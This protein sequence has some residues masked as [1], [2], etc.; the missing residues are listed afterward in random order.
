MSSSTITVEGWRG[1]VDPQTLSAGIGTP[2]VVTT[3]E[4][5][6]GEEIVAEEQ[7]KE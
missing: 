7:F 5:C 2:L 3:L 4:Q 6:P 1:W